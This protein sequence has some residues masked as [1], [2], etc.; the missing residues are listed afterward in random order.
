M[1]V[2]WHSMFRI[3]TTLYIEEYR[4]GVGQLWPVSQVQ[5]TVCFSKWNFI[6]L[7]LCSFNIILLM[8]AFVLFNSILIITTV[9]PPNIKYILSGLLQRKFTNSRY[10][11]LRCECMLTKRKLKYFYKNCWSMY[12][13]KNSL[14]LY[15]ESPIKNKDYD[16]PWMS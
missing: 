13:S 5:P 7:H 1:S 16:H 3:Y 9:I 2:S 6:G 14:K 11:K 8:A 10:T 12:L 15:S 4:A